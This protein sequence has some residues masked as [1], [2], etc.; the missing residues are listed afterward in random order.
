V[1][2]DL[3]YRRAL[4]VANPV[5]GQ[6]RGESVG[7][8]LRE[9]LGRRGLPTDLHLTS[10]P[11]DARES[12]ADL[13]SEV[14]LVISV[15]GDGTLREIL[16][17]LR[18]RP[19]SAN[20]VR[21]GVLPMGTGNALCADLGLPRDVDGALEVLLRGKTVDID[22]ADVN[23][24]LCFL[25]TGIGPDALVVE[26]IAARRKGRP[27]SKWAYLPC[28]IRAFLRYRHEPLTVELDG[29]RLEDTYSQ[30]LACNMIHYGGLVKLSPERILDDGLFEVF[31]FR[32]HHRLQMLAYTLRAFLHMI[33]GG[34][35]EMRR[36]SRIKVTSA[37]PV[38]YY[39][40]GDPMGK[41]PVEIEVTGS[42]FQLLVP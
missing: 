40:D 12:V 16:T 26:D 41:T 32:G 14:D 35:V 33:P 1:L 29:H 36:A 17:G 10:R 18:D 38:P 2:S 5:S 21:V 30:V 3:P 24:E 20:P 6:G 28:G 22:V 37:S 23:G 15:G 4:V 11:D 8:E 19:P 9:G 31:L 13:A 42:R 27:M 7:C 39:V 25:I 34:S